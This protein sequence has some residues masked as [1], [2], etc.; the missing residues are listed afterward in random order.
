MAIPTISLI[1]PSSVFA[2]GQLITITGTNFRTAYPAPPS[3]NGPLPM[4]PPTMTVMIG[5][6]AATKVVV[7]SATELTCF[8]PAGRPGPRSAPNPPVGV[9]VQNLNIA[10]APIGGETATAAAALSYVRA[11]LSIDSD[12]TRVVRTL[13]NLLKDQAID[14]VTKQT[15]VDFSDTPGAS[16]FDITQIASLPC[17]VVSGPSVK[18][19]NFYDLDRRLEIAV[20]GGYQTRL[21]FLTVDLSFKI[22]G[23]DDHE[24]RA[25][26]LFALVQQVFNINSFLVMDRDGTDPSKG[27]VS[28]EMVWRPYDFNDAANNSDVRSFS[29]E[30]LIR[31]F[32]FEDVAGFSNRVVESGGIVDTVEVNAAGFTPGG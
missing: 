12:F 26:N 20:P 17:L 21:T 23:Y 16:E 11:D 31:G 24:A 2:S 1:S 25:L 18:E 7:M 28:Y 4:P 13:I 5:G 15:S 22:S 9:T 8:T 27:T 30:V 10:G 14:N 3:N 32:Q 19:N 29:G 6:V